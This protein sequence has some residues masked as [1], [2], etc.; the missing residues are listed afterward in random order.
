VID[1][2]WLKEN[3][4][5]KIYGCSFS[6]CRWNMYQIHVVS[7]QPFFKFEHD[8]WQ[9]W[10]YRPYSY[11]SHSILKFSCVLFTWTTTILVRSTLNSIQEFCNIR[12]IYIHMYTHPSQK[13]QYLFFVLNMIWSFL[14]NRMINFYYVY[15]L[16][17]M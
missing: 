2:F 15:F 9:E 7:G 12:C 17:Q 4:F 6:C 11:I 5:K 10:I 16:F 13:T 1:G 8:L 14:F 3:C